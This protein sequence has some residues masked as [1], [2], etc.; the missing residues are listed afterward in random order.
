MDV[1]FGMSHSRA[2]RPV[3]GLACEWIVF[4]NRL[5]ACFQVV[6]QKVI[7]NRVIDQYRGR[8]GLPCFA[9]LIQ[10]LGHLGAVVPP[11]IYRFFF[12]HVLCDAMYKQ[13]ALFTTQFY[14]L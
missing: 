8:K 5:S 3:L 7:E 2:P 4:Q 10:P 6:L 1:G 11:V 12:T 13:N 9:I 14:C